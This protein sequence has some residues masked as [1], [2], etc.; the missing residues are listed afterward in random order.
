[1]RVSLR[2]PILGAEEFAPK[3]RLCEVHYGGE[4]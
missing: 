4:V 1:M 2:I 3:K